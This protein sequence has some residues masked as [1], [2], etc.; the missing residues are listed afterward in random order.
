MNAIGI[1]VSKGISTVAVIRPFGEIVRMPFDVVHTTKELNELADFIRSLDGES[2][3]VMESTG[4]YSEPIANA[5]CEA[6]IFVCAINA[7][8]IHDY[9]G[10]TIRRD[11]NDY[12]DSLKIAGY[13]LDKWTKLTRYAPADELRKTL[14]VYNRQLGQYQKLKTM[15]KNNLIAL[16]DQTFPDV[17]KLFSSPARASDGHEKWIDFVAQ[18]WHSECVSSLSQKTFTVRYE[19]WCR[20]NGYNFSAGKAEEVYVASTGYFSTLP[21]NNFT[22]TLITGAVLQLN[23]LCETVATLK[24]EMNKIASELP[25]YETVLA[26]HGVGRS[27]APQLIAEIGDINCFPKRSSLARFAGIEPPENQSGIYSQHSRRIS[28]QGSPHLRRALFQVMCCVLQLSHRDEPTFQFI[29]R[30]RAEGKPYKVY[31]I[32][33][34]NKFLRIYY[35]RVKECFSALEPSA[36]VDCQA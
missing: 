11:K 35:A 14:R 18:F 17:N 6:G 13:C 12:I 31:M 9:G 28:K 23:S 22:K 29:D 27:L 25:E 5:L 34:A 19:K 15:L 2:R 32:A 10:D 8:L 33:G 4:R 30:K 26:M 20:K 7:K 24:T 36:V 3:V 1:D 16:L 21:Q